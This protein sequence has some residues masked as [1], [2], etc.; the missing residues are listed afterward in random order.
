MEW[1]TI[2]LV[3]I[4]FAI[5]LYLTTCA[6]YFIFHR[7]FILFPSRGL[8]TTPSDFQLQYEELFFQTADKMRLQGWY[9]KGETS[10]EWDGM[11]FV[12]FPGN[13][14]SIS[15]FL[16]QISYLAKAGLNVFLFGYRGFGKSEKKRPTEK[17]VY[18]DSEAACEYLL[19]EKNISVKNMIFFGQ[20]L[21]CAMAA[22][23]ASR[24]H[25][26]ALIL[27]GGFSSLVEVAAQAVK[28][29]P[30]RLLTTSRFETKKFLS[31]VECPV[32][33]I[34]S[35][36]DKA[37]PLSHADDLFNAVPGQKKK[38]II[39]GPHAKGLEQ[40]SENCLKEIMQFLRTIR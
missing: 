31:K 10:E 34:H 40:D 8:S 32:L 39:S 9:I 28:W 26:R 30:L 14:G 27:E 15:D 18:E 21:G 19:R 7:Y 38:V 2:V 37:I 6:G 11:N 20:S 17:G 25:P 4:F 5:I 24:F 1:P 3:L 23:M 35:Y 33:I 22:L 36:E 13:K 16:E 12:F 29:L